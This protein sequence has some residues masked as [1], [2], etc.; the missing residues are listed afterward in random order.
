[1]VRLYR[2]L[3]SGKFKFVDI[4]IRSLAHLYVQQGYIVM[5]PIKRKGTSNGKNR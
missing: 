2:L 4:G 1:M 3:K 5:Y